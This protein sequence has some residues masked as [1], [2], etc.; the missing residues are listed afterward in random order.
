MD[1]E[2]DDLND[3]YCDKCA[4][5]FYDLID[6]LVTEVKHLELKVVGLRHLLSMHLPAYEGEMLRCDI[7]RDLSDSFWA[8]PAYQ[9]YISEYY[10]GFDPMDSV[11]YN[12]LLKKSSRGEEFEGF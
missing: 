5:E 2:W 12:D 11:S 7:F 6:Q 9:K 8:R 10:G 4:L 3:F 1:C